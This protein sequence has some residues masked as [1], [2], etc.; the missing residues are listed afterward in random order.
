[1]NP[2]LSQDYTVDSRYRGMSRAQDNASG[3]GFVSSFIKRKELDKPLS[4]PELRQ[5]D[6]FFISGP[7]DSQYTFRNGFT[8]NK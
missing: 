5:E 4:G 2:Q 1:M 8:V 7:G 6:R 3:K